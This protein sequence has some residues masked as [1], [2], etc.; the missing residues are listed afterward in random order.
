M[1]AYQL[2][3]WSLEELLPTPDGPEIEAAIE[4]IEI[5][6]GEFE[7]LREKLD[8]DIDFEDFMDCIELQEKNSRVLWKMNQYAGLHFY[9]DARDQ[10]AQAAGGDALQ[11]GGGLGETRRVPVVDQADRA[12]LDPFGAGQQR[13][14]DGPAVEHIGFPAA[15]NLRDIPIHEG[16]FE[17]RRFHRRH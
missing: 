15:R 7:G 5:K 9:E 17:S 3:R 8:A 11:G 14:G 10:E 4:Q 6:V 2:S 12:D 13:R 16:R 1:T